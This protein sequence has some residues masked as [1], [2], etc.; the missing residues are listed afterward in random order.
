MKKFY[1][2]LFGHEFKIT[3]HVTRHVK[4][5]KCINCNKQFTTDQSG[6]I[7]ELTPNLREINAL[8]EDIHCKRLLKR[9][10]QHPELLVFRH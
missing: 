5:F 4:E 6:N 8:L 2:S 1:C 9:Q 10:K 3:K 7:T